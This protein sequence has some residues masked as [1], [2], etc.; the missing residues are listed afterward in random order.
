MSDGLMNKVVGLA[1]AGIIAA[2]LLPV[3]LNQLFQANQSGWGA[4]TITVFNLLP[5]MIVIAAILGFIA[6]VQLKK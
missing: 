5:L 3:A 1:V 2:V 4:T 6:Y